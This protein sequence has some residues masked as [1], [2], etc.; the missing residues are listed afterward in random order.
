M[1][2]VRHRL[3]LPLLSL[4]AVGLLDVHLGVAGVIGGKL[5]V[6]Y[7]SVDNSRSDS[8]HPGGAGV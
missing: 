5:M 4:S 7:S 3:R 2:R 8:C 6:D 1:L